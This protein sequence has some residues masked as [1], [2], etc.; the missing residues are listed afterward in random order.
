MLTCTVKLPVIVTLETP[1]VRL[2]PIHRTE[3]DMCPGGFVEMSQRNR[4][5]RRTAEACTGFPS[6]LE[7]N[8]GPC[9]KYM[10]GAHEHDE[11][12]DSDYDSVVTMALVRQNLYTIF[13]LPLNAADLK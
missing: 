11:K 1:W 2:Q 13:I 7:T 9:R 6:Y 4:E 10:Y 12:R 3:S 8:H 5:F